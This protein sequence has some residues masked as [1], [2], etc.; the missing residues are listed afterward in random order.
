M[1]D[2]SQQVAPLG[3]PDLSPQ[4][5]VRGQSNEGWVPSSSSGDGAVS[6]GTA[7]QLPSTNRYQLPAPATVPGDPPYAPYSAPPS[8]YG[9]DYSNTVAPGTMGGQ[10][11]VAP[12]AFGFQNDPLSGLDIPNISAPGGYQPRVQVAPLD[13]YLQEARTGRVI[14]GG[15][16]NSD[17]G[18][19]GQLIIDE[20]NFDIRAFPRTWSDIF[21]GYAF[22]GAGQSFRAELMP[23]NLVERYTV[24]WATPNMFGYLPYSL[25]VGGYLFSRLYRD[26]TEQ[27]LGGRVGLGYAVTKDLSIG[28]EI[29]GENVK[30]MNPRIQGVQSLDDVLG[31]SELYTA[32]FR[33]NRDT[34][35]SVFLATEGTLLEMIYDQSFGTFDFP[36]AQV[37]FSHYSRVRERADGMGR[38][39]LVNTWRLGISG[40]NT[41]IYENFFAGGFSTLRGFRFRGASP[42]DGGVQVGGRFMFLGSLEYMFP[43]TA[44]EMLRGV[45]FVDYGTIEQ[46]ITFNSDTFRVAPGLGIRVAVPALGPAPLAFDFAVPVAKADGDERQLLSFYMGFTR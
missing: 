32:R 20:R 5:V 15:S 40:N 1:N 14:L 28:T 17:L 30:I 38:H 25:S 12:G 45:A 29:R 27:R 31:D 11:T 22:R 6:N 43:L 2:L 46:D 36:Q 9:D 26:W 10:T 16:V 42:L 39:V 21:S 41:P 35:D 33:I 24:N 19:A 13:V 7:S 37:N 23:G 8:G 34:R 4:A 44:D 3:L 18:V